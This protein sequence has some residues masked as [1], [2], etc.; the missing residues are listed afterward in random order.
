[1]GYD[2]AAL[3]SGSGAVDASQINCNVPLT[4]AQRM[5]AVR[6]RRNNPLRHYTKRRRKKKGFSRIK[7]H[8][9]GM[10]YS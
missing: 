8:P 6:R 10:L 2:D 3:H 5:A 9:S 4:E 7:K 1:M